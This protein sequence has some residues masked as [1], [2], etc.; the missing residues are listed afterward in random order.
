MGFRFRKTI[1]LLPGVR[2]NLSKTGVSASIG[3]RGATVNLSD[4][5][6]RGTVGLPGTGLSYT[7]QLSSAP[8]R[9]G[10]WFLAILALAVA[11]GLGWFLLVL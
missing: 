3:E 5:G 11:V 7:G 9:P 8:R 6:A 4:R 1:K 10:R 2:L